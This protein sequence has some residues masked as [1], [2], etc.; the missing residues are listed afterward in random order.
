MLVRFDNDSNRANPPRITLLIG[1]RDNDR[2][3]RPGGYSKRLDGAG[4]ELTVRRIVGGRVF[5]AW[6]AY[7]MVINGSGEFDLVPV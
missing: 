6:R 1:T 4:I 5:G 3:A 7:G 2:V